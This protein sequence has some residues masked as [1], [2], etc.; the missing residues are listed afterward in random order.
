MEMTGRDV[1]Q[2][3]SFGFN[4]KL[5]DSDDGWQTQDYGYRTYDYRL[6]RFLSQDPLR[7]YY[8]ELTPYQFA[9]NRPIDGIDLDGLEWSW[10]VQKGLTKDGKT[11]Y[12]IT[13]SIEVNVIGLEKLG[14]DF[15]K[16]VDAYIK[17]KYKGTSTEKNGSIIEF[18]TVTK[19]NQ[20]WSLPTGSNPG[21]TVTLE[22]KGQTPLD[23][24]SY[25]ITTNYPV[26]D[27]TK[28][29][30]LAKPFGVDKVNT[31]YGYIRLFE[32]K[33]TSDGEEIISYNDIVKTFGHEIGHLLFGWIHDGSGNFSESYKSLIEQKG[34]N[35]MEWGGYNP[36]DRIEPMQLKMGVLNIVRDQ[37]IN[38]YEKKNKNKQVHFTNGMFNKNESKQK[39]RPKL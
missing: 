30:D 6:G 10:K 15:L 9:S 38:R 33:N 22:E 4:G 8:P 17:E 32:K 23:A 12:T 14:P 20:I 29:V 25:G 5:D 13:L 35:V 37:K 28:S 24:L 1:N 11:K 21:V 36:L 16:D 34:P 18:N 7:Q 31:Q 19:F 26:F 27:P 39:S 3:Y 2:G